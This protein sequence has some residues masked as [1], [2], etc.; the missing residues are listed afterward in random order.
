MGNLCDLC[1]GSYVVFVL[2][3][4]CAVLCCVVA[5]C[6]IKWSGFYFFCSVWF[7]SV[8]VS[9]YFVCSGF[10]F[11]FV[12]SRLCLAR[13][14]VSLSTV[15]FS[16]SASARSAARSGLFFFWAGFQVLRGGTLS[17]KVAALTLQVQESPV[18][19]M[20]VLDGLLDLGMK[21]ERR[22]VRLDVLSCVV[23]LSIYTAG[24]GINILTCFCGCFF[25]RVLL[26][27]SLAFSVFF[28]VC[29]AC[30]FLVRFFGLL[31]RCFCG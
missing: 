3:L 20:A 21:K 29:F 1:F 13:S 12:L 15:F 14:R 22:T 25:V 2:C 18:H 17:D 28:S 4:C 30:F 31:S 5:L 27:F 8:V 7:W 10:G 11:S 26:R 9:C 16:F 19:R 6:C 24:R 23:F